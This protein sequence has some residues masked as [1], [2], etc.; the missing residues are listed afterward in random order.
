MT[1]V[2]RRGLLLLCFAL[3]CGGL[4]ASQV[5]QRERRVEATLGPLVPVV[6]AKRELPAERRLRPGDLGVRHVPA[7]FAPPDAL[8]GSG[9]L[10]GARTRVPVASGGYLT[11]GVLG[12]GAPDTGAGPLRAGER[13][14]ELAVAG[15]GA[16]ATAEPG[17]RVDVLVTSTRED[18]GG[19]TFVALEN[20]ELM[21]QRAGS[22]ERVAAGRAE[23]AAEP[24][25]LAT[26]RVSARQAVYLTAAANFATEI[27]LLVRPPGDR[28]RVGAAGVAA[29]GL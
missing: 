23:G 14:L 13:A 2:R 12:G 3:V 15:G 20:V 25:S 1:A 9:D 21:G 26:L 28:E 8:G 10:T 19:R 6:V 17:A 24:N 16:L 18:G 4:A 22:D 29:S 7:R 5:R 27:R 11:V